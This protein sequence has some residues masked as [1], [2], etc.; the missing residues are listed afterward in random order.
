MVRWFDAASFDMTMACTGLSRASLTEYCL[1]RVGKRSSPNP[2]TRSRD[3]SHSLSP[4]AIPVRSTVH[5]TGWRRV[6]V[7]MSFE[8][9]LTT[10]FT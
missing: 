6:G 8:L 7:S 4:T 1:N 5:F 2:M 3:R 10:T 9:M